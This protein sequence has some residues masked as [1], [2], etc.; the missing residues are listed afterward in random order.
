VVSLSP[1]TSFRLAA[2]SELAMWLFVLVLGFAPFPLGL[3]VSWG[4]GLSAILIAACCLIWVLANI[5]DV[6]VLLFRPAIL[7]I[8]SALFGVA[9]LWAF[10]QAFPLFPAWNHPAWEMSSQVLGRSLVGTVSIDPWRTLTEATKLATYAG[11]CWLAFSISRE[12]ERAQRLFDA[13]I[14]IGALYVIYAFGLAVADVA[15]ARLI[16]HQSLPN[17]FL[18][19][20]FML[21]NTFATYC[22]LAALAAVSRFFALS[23]SSL[24]EN[25]GPR[26]FFLSLIQFT[27]DRRAPHLIAALLLFSA[28]AASASRGGFAAMTAGL[29]AMAVI[30]I[31]LAR[32]RER[33]SW[34]TIA[35]G[36]TLVP[37]LAFIITNS[38]KL[39]QRFAAVL[40]AGTVDDIRLA[41]WAAAV[42]MIESAPLRGLGLGTFQDAYPLYAQKVFPFLMDK[43]HCDYLELAAGIGLPAAICCWLAIGC[44]ALYCLRGVFV[45]HRDRFFAMTGFCAVTL[46]AVHSA[47]DFSV[48]IPAVGLS[49]A[50]LLGIGLAQSR[51]SASR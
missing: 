12:R 14:V 24:I 46:V 39:A 25:K 34:S 50:T 29:I 10:L 20:P 23:S 31:G 19:G 40:D 8:P 45:R 47:V 38:E 51:S 44:F 49:F 30:S 41:L 4:A 27:F 6:Q 42:R 37:F 9:L 11:A 26:R 2:G 28:V 32:R 33:R 48:Q 35:M 18:S 21:H 15:Q 5:A 17:P 13:V 1:A 16:Y 3:A 43:A 36:I 7:W 22:G